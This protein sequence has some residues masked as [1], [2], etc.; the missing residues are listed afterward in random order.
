MIKV[1]SREP[2]SIYENVRKVGMNCSFGVLP[3][4]DIVD[5]TKSIC[6]ERKTYPD[7]VK[8]YKSGN[9]FYQLKKM[10]NNYDFCY[11]FISGKYNQAWN[12]SSEQNN[13]LLVDLLLFPKIRMCFF[14]NDKQLVECADE[15]LKRD[16]CKDKKSNDDFAMRLLCCF[17]GV[18]AD[19]ARSWSKNFKVYSAVDTFL[20]MLVDCG[21][22]R[23][24]FLASKELEK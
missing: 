20:R 15:L 14:S 8:S 18:N 21:I 22:D 4:G 19:L 23:L 1:D 7:L 24:K 5:D 10:G 6:I 11:L 3:V 12:W 9:L 2:A 17:E 16:I 13:K